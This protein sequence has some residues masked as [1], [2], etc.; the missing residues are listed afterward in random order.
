MTSAVTASAPARAPFLEYVLL[1]TLAIIWGASFTFI[2][3]GV[4]TI[5]PLTLIAGRTLIAGFLLAG[6]MRLRGVRMPSDARTWRMFAFQAAMNSVF[7]F[8]MIAW[9]SQS[10]DVGLT[11]VLSSTTPIWVFLITWLITRHEPATPRKLFGVCAGIVG[12]TL[13]V[14][15]SVL[16]D[17]GREIVPQLALVVAS[18]FYACAVIYGRNFRGLDPMVPAAGSMLA[19]AVV[20]IPMSLII[21]RPW[22]LFPSVASLVAF[23]CLTIFSTAFAFVIYFRLLRTLGSVG[24][25]SQSYLRAPVGVII[26]IIVLD[27]K[28]SWDLIAGLVL[29]IVAVAAM[30]VPVK[31]V[32][33]PT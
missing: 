28:L 33:E 3:V 23:G 16:F 8:T 19:G 9:A 14:G 25:I 12:V 22:T 5:P 30:A 18:L 26:G 24:S 7:P 4:E 10:L 27:E 31:E 6:I 17:L 21:D 11:T 2:K 20:L 32:K 15:V 13:I 29:V 1:V